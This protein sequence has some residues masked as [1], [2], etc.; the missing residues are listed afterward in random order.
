MNKESTM[1][2][3]VDN[4]NN[5]FN[6]GQRHTPY[7]HTTKKVDKLLKYCVKCKVCWESFY[8]ARGK[9]WTK[10]ENNHIPTLNKKRT[11]CPPCKA[12]EEK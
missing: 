2:D 8:S 4:F 9:R 1:Q 11:L 6:R 3:W 7:A 5:M 12:K 10:Y